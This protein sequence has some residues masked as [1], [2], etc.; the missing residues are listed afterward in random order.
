MT[1]FIFV[2]CEMYLFDDCQIDVVLFAVCVY[3]KDKKIY[4]SKISV[5]IYNRKGQ[6]K[7]Q[8]R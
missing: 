5:Y 3:W 8:R 6:L 1:E 4:K 2:L 7:S